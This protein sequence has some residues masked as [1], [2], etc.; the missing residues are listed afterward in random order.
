MF[1]KTL[2]SLVSGHGTPSKPTHH[3]KSKLYADVTEC[4][5][6]RYT[7]V[8][9]Q[10]VNP[11]LPHTP[12]YP[13][14]LRDRCCARRT[15][16]DSVPAAAAP[17]THTTFTAFASRQNPFDFAL[18][19]DS[20]NSSTANLVHILDD[21]DDRSRR[22][23]TP[24]S[25]SSTGR[26]SGLP[27]EKRDG[28]EPGFEIM[29][30]VV[31]SEIGRAFASVTTTPVLNIDRLQILRRYYRTWLNKS[32]PPPKPTAKVAHVVAIERIGAVSAASPT[33]R[34]SKPVP[35]EGAP[36]EII[37]AD[38]TLSQKFTSR[39]PLRRITLILSRS[40]CDALLPMRS[41]P[42]QF[43]ASTKKT[44]SEPCYFVSLIS[45]HT[46]A[47]GVE[48]VDG[49]G[50]ALKEVLLKP[51]A[52]DVFEL[53]AQQY[54]DCLAVRQRGKKSKSYWTRSVGGR[55]PVRVMFSRGSFYDGDM[56]EGPETYLFCTSC[57]LT[58]VET[59]LGE[60]NARMV[61]LEGLM[62]HEVG[63]V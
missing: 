17:Q 52:K 19:A 47:F 23:T 37:A 1:A 9:L 55:A 20:H 27:S 39:R 35:T 33:T 41:I 29:A 24:F 60:R 61:C 44:T 7:P 57:M 30:N 26:R 12:L 36:A 8:H 51:V 3:E 40:G 58:Y 46:N 42:S 10:P 14:A 22:S 28:E 59:K 54:M 62:G 6:T 56:M 18:R 48:T 13:A 32:L 49:P 34:S 38:E 4:L 11:I 45:K 5:R 50:A 15:T 31:W 43:R 16:Q 53:V 21:A 2:N 63:F 25:T